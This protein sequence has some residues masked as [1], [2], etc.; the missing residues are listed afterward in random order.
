[1]SHTKTVNVKGALLDVEFEF[2][3]ACRGAREGG[4]QLEP[5]EE[6]SIEIT[7]I[8]SR[9]DLSDIL[10]AFREEIEEQCIGNLKDREDDYWIIDRRN[11]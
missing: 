6:A 7:G 3:G 11:R 9:D 2:H 10:A 5:D 4:L 8:T 1:M